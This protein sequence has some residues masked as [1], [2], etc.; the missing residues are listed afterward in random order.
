VS[1]PVIFLSDLGLRDE[2]VGVCHAVIARIAPDSRVIDVTHGV[3]PHDIR[4]GALVLAESLRFAP[5]DA[6]G[7]AIIDPGVG[8]ARRPIAVETAGGRFLVG[9]DNGLLSLAWRADGGA[10]RAVAITSPA[11]VL[12]PI[13]SVFHGRDVFAPAAAHLA[14]GM[15]L[16]EVGPSIVPEDLTEVG[17]G[18]PE[19][20]AGR[21]VGEVLDVDRFGTVR[22]NVH[23]THLAAA[24]LDDAD[25]ISVSTTSQSAAASRIA[26]YGE[27]A[28]GS[29][30]ILVDAWGWMSVIRYEAN[31]AADL[32]IRPGDPVWLTAVAD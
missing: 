7:L 2:F 27:V 11:V 31:A 20:E 28:V 16:D 18:E 32:G 14:A 5:S 12:L 24:G 19:V 29:F 23:P 4:A 30:G 3:T 17:I 8:T 22:L 1:K 6:V 26:S 13:S 25:A 21:V 10:R 9:P 15:E